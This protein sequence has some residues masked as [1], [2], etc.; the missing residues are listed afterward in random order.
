MITWREHR[1]RMRL[2]TRVALFAAGLFAVLALAVTPFLHPSTVRADDG[3]YYDFCTK[4]LG[5]PPDVCCTNAGMVPSGGSC[6]A[7]AVA[8]PTSYPVPTVT[9]QIAPPVVVAPP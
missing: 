8:S 5:Q 4:T 1:M 6:L 2:R 3:D 9:Q 7:S